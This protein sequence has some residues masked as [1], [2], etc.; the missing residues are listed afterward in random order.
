MIP[1]ISGNGTRF[2]TSNT[3]TTLAGKKKKRDVGSKVDNNLYR[4]PD[5]ARRT[6][7]AAAVPSEPLASRILKKKQRFLRLAGLREVE[8]LI[9]SAGGEE[10]KK[11]SIV[12][13]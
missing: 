8:K 3:V 10:V 11:R 1:V 9:Q 4:R 5:F 12:P 7:R 6:D 2:Q 13:R